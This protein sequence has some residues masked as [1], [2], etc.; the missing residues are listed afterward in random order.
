M[1]LMKGMKL[2]ALLLVFS[3]LLSAQVKVEDIKTFTLGNGMKI[4]VLEDHS[5]PMANMYIFFKVGSR[6]EYSG[7]TGL[8]HFFEHMM[9][10]GAQKYGPK[11]FDRVME[12]N[13]GFN[14]AYTSE[15]LTVYTDFYPSNAVEVICDLEA[16]RIAHLALDD[17]MV[18]SERG[19]ILAERITGME[20]S[21]FQLLSEHVRGAA[22][23][24]HPYRWEVIGY[25]SDIRN[26][27]KS[28]LQ[29]Y[30]DTYYAPN[31]AVVAIVGDV[32]IEEIKELSKKYFEP[33]PARTAPRPVHAREPEQLGEKRLYVNRD[34]AS[35]NILAVYHIPE[36]GSKDRYALEML[37][38]ILG[39][40]KSS[41]LYK[42][43]V[44]EKQVA[45]EIQTILWRSLDPFL[46]QIYAICARDV[47]EDLLEKAIYEE[48][49]KVIKDGVT[50]QE[51]QK[52]KNRKLME[53]YHIM[54][55][56]N[57]K[58]NNLGIYEIYFGSYEKLFSAPEEYQKISAAD[59]KRVAATYFKKSNRTVGI[60]KCMEE[61]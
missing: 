19:V 27:R 46:Y 4:I 44:D 52:A 54:E 13:G 56:N 10:N 41:R 23:L 21:N 53:F 38:S 6:N 24:V 58:A 25:E 51:L 7:I 49:D 59:V 26:W 45:V 37:D 30:F 11:M 2:M 8:S 32:D 1:N 14:N 5:I 12:A 60:L 55:T 48:I 3:S 20:N 16:D 31:N 34:V 61:K 33:I 36:S 47:S 42:A 29:A 18:E 39:E 15:D 28:D 35:P 9:F 43:L 40:G 50:E 57:G 22:F 17:K